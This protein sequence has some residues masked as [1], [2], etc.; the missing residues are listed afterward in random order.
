M[1][2]TCIWIT[3][4]CPG[5]IRSD[6]K[7]P[8]PLFLKC[9]VKSGDGVIDHGT[10][11][12]DD[13]YTGPGFVEEIRDDKPITIL[14]DD[15][16]NPKTCNDICISKG[17]KSGECKAFRCS[18]GTLDIGEGNCPSD[19]KCCC[20]PSSCEDIDGECSNRCVYGKKENKDAECGGFMEVCCVPDYSKKFCER[21][22]ALSGHE[23]INGRCAARECESG[24][25]P[26]DDKLECSSVCCIPDSDRFENIRCGK[27]TGDSRTKYYKFT[28]ADSKYVDFIMTPENGI[29]AHLYVSW[30][31]TWPISDDAWDCIPLS[32]AGKKETCSKFLESGTYYFKVNRVKHPEDDDSERYNIGLK[33]SDDLYEFVDIEC[34]RQLDSSEFGTQNYKFDMRGPKHVDI[35]LHPSYGDK[36]LYASWSGTWPVSDDAWEC[37]PF[38]TKGEEETCSK[39]LEPGIYYFKVDSDGSYYRAHIE[40][41]DIPEIDARLTITAIKDEYSIGEKVDLTG[42]PQVT[43]NDENNHAPAIKSGEH[44]YKSLGDMGR[45]IIFKSDAPHENIVFIQFKEEPVSDRKTRLEKDIES[46]EKKLKTSP[47]LYRYTLGQADTAS[48]LWD[49]WALDGKIKTYSQELKEKIREREQNIFAEI[50]KPQLA[51]Y[52]NDFYGIVY[53]LSAE[54]TEKIKHLPYVKEA[55]QGFEQKAGEYTLDTTPPQIHYVTGDPIDRGMIMVTARATD[56]LSGIEKCEVYLSK[57]RILDETDVYSGE[58]K[59]G[60]ALDIITNQRIDVTDTDSTS[61]RSLYE[62]HG[63]VDVYVPHSYSGLVRLSMN[64]RLSGKMPVAVIHSVSYAFYLWERVDSSEFE[65]EF[66]LQDSSS[67]SVARIVPGKQTIDV[68]FMTAYLLDET[69]TEPPVWFADVSIEPK[70]VQAY[71]GKLDPQDYDYVIVK[72]INKAGL[73]SYEA[74]EHSSKIKPESVIRNTGTIDI[75]GYLVMKI[76]EVAGPEDKVVVNN[77]ATGTMRTIP[78]GGDLALDII[79][80][81]AGSYTVTKAGTYHVYAALLDKDDK[82]IETASGIMGGLYQFTVPG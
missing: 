37:I 26:F 2:G 11:M 16:I 71:S 18:S 20:T 48:I 44:Q 79:W 17:H 55:Y 22:N 35:I 77:A 39:Y 75:D 36:H 7:C 47:P 29:D 50:K 56:S 76:S 24:E 10:P 46:R 45:T 72:A 78:A 66:K 15:P 31:G 6:Y 57:D 23:N 63:L 67:S 40:C 33:C 59:K 34:G 65:G 53:D 81:D 1:G 41:S 12:G 8:I 73:T 14:T 43:P 28:L 62:S 49:K 13:K 38:S 21:A 19:E 80:A 60:A 58:L 61:K 82:V 5:E 9:C 74:A 51:K 70:D 42:A 32:V 30:S 54:E 27:Q 52:M 4:K 64:G 25:I 3:G 68:G 69:P